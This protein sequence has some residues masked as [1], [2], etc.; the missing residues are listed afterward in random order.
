MILG[1]VESDPVSVRSRVACAVAKTPCVS[2]GTGEGG[3]EPSEIAFMNGVEQKLRSLGGRAIVTS[4][5]SATANL[6]RKSVGDTS[7]AADEQVEELPREVPE[8]ELPREL[9]GDVLRRDLQGDGVRGSGELTTFS[10]TRMRPFVGKS[11]F[12][13]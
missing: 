2:F 1:G 7:E 5:V 3:A 9:H 6:C 8:A 11:P 4:R 10:I 12:T 13:A